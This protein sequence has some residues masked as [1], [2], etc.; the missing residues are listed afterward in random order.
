MVNYSLSGNAI[1]NSDYTLSGTPNQIMIPP[2]Q[3]SGSVTLTAITMKTRG[4][5]KTTMTIDQGTDYLLPTFGR[6]MK[7]KP[8]KE[9]VTINNK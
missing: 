2:N 5:E 4:R 7:V 3:T 6:R 8:P 1:F 9:T